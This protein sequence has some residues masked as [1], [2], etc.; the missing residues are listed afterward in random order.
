MKSLKT[1]ITLMMIGA[2]T[3]VMVVA[4]VFGVVAIREIGN[5]AADRI[6]LLLCET[7]EKNLDYYFE[8]VEQSVEMV[9]AYV[10]ADLNGLETE[11]LRAH[12][13]RARDIFSRLSEQTNGVITYY[14]RIDP[15]ISTT[16]KGFWYVN[17]DGKGFQEHEVTD[18]T[19][20][21]TADTSRLVWFTVPKFT[22]QPVWL[23]PYIT[24]NLDVRV[25]SYNE[26]IYYDGVFVGVVGIEIDY[27][28]MASEVDSITLFDSGY[29][30]INDAEGTI[31]YHP[32][33]DVKELAEN[34][35]KVPDGLLSEDTFIRYDFE[36]TEKKAVWLT[37]SNGMRLN[38]TV[39]LSEIDELWQDWV[40]NLLVVFS[41]LLIVCIVLAILF[42]GRITKPLTALTEA[43]K[44]VDAGN[45]DFELEYDGE[46]EIGI[47]THT[48]KDLTAHLKDYIRSLNNL[49]YAD[50]LTSLHNKGAFDQCLQNME[51]KMTDSD[52]ELEFA[53]CIFDCNDLKKV[54]DQNGHEKGDIYLK[55]TAAMICEVFRHSPVFRIGG[56]E[57][58]AVLLN[59]DYRNREE[60]L[61]TFDEKC[62]ATRDGDADIWEQVNVARGMAAYNPNED[63]SV[64]DV[65]RRADKLMYE[66]KWKHKH[67]I[68]EE[69]DEI[70]NLRSRYALR[71][72]FEMY[73]RIPLH[74]MV[75]DL[76]EFKTLNETKG[77]EY[78][79][80][81]LATVGKT[82][83]ECFRRCHS[84]RYGGDEF[85]VIG[86]NEP[87]HDFISDC[88]TAKKMLEASDISFSAGYV[89]G[90]PEEI[91]DLRNMISQA[92]EML[93]EA[94]KAGKDQF[95]GNEFDR[96]HALHE[97]AGPSRR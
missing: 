97:K 20:Y 76:D 90:I 94:K 25:I 74:V 69:K 28:T 86:E 78:G 50:A 52:G 95:R 29:A 18:I 36:G 64:S 17:L 77:H 89:H 53:V 80:M 13:L 41:I 93:Y 8:S 67:H 48:F 34:H 81:I 31:I 47:L 1:K 63:E 72:D 30:F 27:S 33:M 40:R 65:V 70:T 75:L 16:E 35:P 23:P 79:N 85:L 4:A 66:H 5:R 49:A 43:A 58:A 46:D 37:L 62:R 61:R 56:D 14:Y 57:F 15:S 42:A 24:D 12:L 39:P 6:L 11:Q 82:L 21:D 7:G 51:T 3:V 87:D 71:Q 73:L 54:N 2:I 19:L 88:D 84:Y 32:H 55:E 91:Q 44:Q 9:S 10:E 59:S 68:D 26:P 45:Y 83:T 22:G 60:L 38:V 96:S 92:D